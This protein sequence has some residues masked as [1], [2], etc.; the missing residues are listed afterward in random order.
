MRCMCG[1]AAAA[2]NRHSCMHGAGV[3]CLCGIWCGGYR[4]R[5]CGQTV[6]RGEQRHDWCA[7]RCEQHKLSSRSGQ[8][9]GKARRNFDARIHIFKPSFMISSARRN[10]VSMWLCT[11]EE[12]PC[13]GAR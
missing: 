3:G 13:Q 10:R 5:W 6:T 12:L 4:A 8:T 7:A 1:A 2:G 9:G 11:S